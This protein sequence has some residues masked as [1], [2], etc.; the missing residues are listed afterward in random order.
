MSKPERGNSKSLYRSLTPRAREGTA[1]PKNSAI[2]RYPVLPSGAAQD[3]AP[4]ILVLSKDPRSLASASEKAYHAGN[5]TGGS[6]IC[7]RAS[8]VWIYRR[9]RAFRRPGNGR[10]KLCNCASGSTFTHILRPVESRRPGWL[11]YLSRGRHPKH[12]RYRPAGPL[13]LRKRTVGGDRPENS[14]TMN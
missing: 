11:A 1:E 6:R 5:N 14:K 12:A 9:E 3:L 4:W 8:G 2:L 13:S 10:H 7:R